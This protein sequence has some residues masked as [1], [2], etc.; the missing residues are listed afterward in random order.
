MASKN[1]FNLLGDIDPEEEEVPTVDEKGKGDKKKAKPAA[2]GKAA[3]PA[4]TEGKIAK[5][6]YAQ[7]ILIFFILS[8]NVN[9]VIFFGYIVLYHLTKIRNNLKFIKLPQIF[10]FP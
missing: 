3:A 8:N 6:Y 1:I 5:K 10:I 7:A 9:F 4:K 2:S